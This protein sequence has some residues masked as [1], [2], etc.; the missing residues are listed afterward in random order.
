MMEL[1]EIVT[2]SIELFCLV[3]FIV[4]FSSWLL[5][6]LKKREVKPRMDPLIIIYSEEPL[7]QEYLLR[8]R[9]NER[10]VLINKNYGNYAS[11]LNYGGLE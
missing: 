2:Y 4:V 3:S 1:M 8:K 10:F 5:F 11:N 9:L 7:S 6:R